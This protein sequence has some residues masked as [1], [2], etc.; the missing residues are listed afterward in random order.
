[1][2]TCNRERPWGCGKQ[3]TKN[4]ASSLSFPSSFAVPFASSSLRSSLLSN[5]GA[6]FP[7]SMP[8]S[9]RWK[10]LYLVLSCGPFWSLPDVFWSVC[11][12]LG[13]LGPSPGSTS[14]AEPICAKQGSGR[15]DRNTVW[16]GSRS[17][18]SILRC[19]NNFSPHVWRVLTELERKA[20]L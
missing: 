5:T 9:S 17:V 6:S 4:L 13:R 15:M 19:S 10:S 11:G 20:V 18:K 8:C 12:T 1:M 3:T 2:G 7:A 14:L 16:I